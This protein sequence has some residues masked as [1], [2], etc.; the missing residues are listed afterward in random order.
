MIRIVDHAGDTHC[1]TPAARPLILVLAI[2]DQ[3]LVGAALGML[4]ASEPDIELHCCREAANAI[5]LANQLGP[6]IILQDLHMPGI[7]GLTLVRLFRANPLT[8]RT[9]IVM[10]SGNDDEVSRA[11]SLAEGVK[12]YLVKLPAKA[13]LIACIRRHASGNAGRSDTID[14]AVMDAFR[15]AGAPAFMRRLIDQFLAEAVSRVQALRD[16]AGRDDAPELRAIAHSLKGSSMIMGATQLA[17][18]CVQ[19][20]DHLDGQAEVV[21]PALMTQ[22][23]QELVRVQDALAAQRQGSDER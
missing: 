12:D 14:T 5:A 3:P 10:L 8:A 20:E 21:M 17:A 13:D 23:E 1:A 6:A 9:P 16:A 15:E 22:I 18:L 19:V 7:D 4:L 2:D 11:R